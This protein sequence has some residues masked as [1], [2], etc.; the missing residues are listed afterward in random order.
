MIGCHLG[1]FFFFDQADPCLGESWKWVADSFLF[2]FLGLW[3]SFVILKSEWWKR[4]EWPQRS[5]Q[6]CGI[7]GNIWKDCDLYFGPHTSESTHPMLT[8]AAMKKWNCVLMLDT[9]LAVAE[10]TGW[11]G[12]T[13]LSAHKGKHADRQLQAS[14][15]Q[16]Q[17]CV[18]LFP[19][20]L[21]NVHSYSYSPPFFVRSIFLSLVRCSSLVV[22]TSIG[23]LW[24]WAYK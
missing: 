20:F 6:C 21:Y 13:H 14:P 23:F 11:H 5:C 3:P 19:T 10:Q 8:C 24:A 4:V 22:K 15:L 18:Y 17:A 1:L 16:A 9:S 2:F 7:I 12:Y